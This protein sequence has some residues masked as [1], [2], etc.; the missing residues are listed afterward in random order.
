MI[1]K[2]VV[3]M[4]ERKL[5]TPSHA[6]VVARLSY[7]LVQYIINNKNGELYG[8]NVA[9]Y[10]SNDLSYIQPDITVML[11]KRAHL[12]KENGIFGAPDLIVNVEAEE[13]RTDAEE[14]FNLLMQYASNGVTECWIVNL[15]NKTID[16][17]DTDGRDFHQ[18]TDSLVLPGI[19]LSKNIIFS[20]RHFIV[21]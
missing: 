19:F 8:P 15:R 14:R 10:L 18:I 1:N 12:V 13:H 17:Y 2:E 21:D 7:L 6:S 3:M 4:D 11:N 9:V 20:K 16:I 5:I